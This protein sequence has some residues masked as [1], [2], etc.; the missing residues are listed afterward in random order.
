[1]VSGYPTS[2]NLP[3]VDGLSTDSRDLRCHTKLDG[4]KIKVGPHK[5]SYALIPKSRSFVKLQEIGN[6]PTQVIFGLKVI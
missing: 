4:S 6:F 2:T 5:E 3:R 1:M